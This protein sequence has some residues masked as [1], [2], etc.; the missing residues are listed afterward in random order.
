MDSTQNTKFDL[1]LVG[2]L[3][4]CMFGIV[5]GLYFVDMRTGALAS[6]SKRLYSAVMDL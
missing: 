1:I 2:V 4:L 6:A 5:V 3:L